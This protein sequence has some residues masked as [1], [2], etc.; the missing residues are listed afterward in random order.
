M[1]QPQTEI[2]Q[3]TESLLGAI[4]NTQINFMAI[5]EYIIFLTEWVD[6]V[7]KLVH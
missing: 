1:I 5:K 7:Q 2:A 6:L 3:I 4:N